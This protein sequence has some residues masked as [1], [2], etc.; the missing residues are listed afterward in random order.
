MNARTATALAAA[1]VVILA[2][3]LYFGTQ[4]AQLG[5]VPQ[6]QLAFPYLTAK[7]QNTTALEVLHHGD[8]LKI[9][10]K[11]DSW[12]LPAKDGY[13]ANQ[14]R[15]RALL[16]ALSEL[17]LQEPRTADPADYGKLGVED[18][19]AKDAG[20]TEVRVLDD[21]GGAIAE[22]IVGHQ[23]A[24]SNGEGDAE[25]VRKPS[26]AQAWLATGQLSVETDPQQWVE[27]DIVD[28]QAD[29]IGGITVLRNGAE[30][31]LARDG[32]TMNVVK[33][34]DHPKLDQYKIDDMARAL[35]KL[36]LT[37]VKRRPAP[38]D[39]IGQAELTAD[40]MKV[41]VTVNKSGPD[42]WLQLAA[43]GDGTAQQEAAALDA[44][45]KDWAYQVAAWKEQALVPTMDDLKAREPPRPPAAA[46]A[47]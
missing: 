19:G 40:G 41:T 42:I 2:L 29:K 44:K 23:R 1:A 32:G 47:K 31:D 33:P 43:T 18:A 35:E 13:T 37:G 21:T 26:E 10:R 28:I 22:L 7:L 4:R 25:Y 3:G 6:G 36:T 11:G 39:T 45:V 24:G 30:I 12:V 20:S 5:D 27:Q 9:A 8:T 16:T 14:S 38:G 17:K 34:A 15:V 46:P